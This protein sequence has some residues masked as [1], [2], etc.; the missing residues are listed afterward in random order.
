M[1]NAIK[2]LATHV[3]IVAVEDLK[4]KKPK[5]K[6]VYR[7]NMHKLQ[8]QDAHNFIFSEK[9]REFF[10]AWCIIAGHN[11]EHIRKSIRKEVIR[12]GM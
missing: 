11:P 1:K 3:L 9:D 4:R 5:T 2:N 6:D 7:L 10:D 8:Q 12:N